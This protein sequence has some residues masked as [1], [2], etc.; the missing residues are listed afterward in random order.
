LIFNT[1]KLVALRIYDSHATKR[2]VE[3]Y[4]FSKEDLDYLENLD[5]TVIKIYRE[6]EL[7]S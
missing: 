1:G 2:H 5:R 7:A 3:R 4:E 6:L